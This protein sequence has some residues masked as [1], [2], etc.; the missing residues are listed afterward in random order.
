MAEEARNSG[1]KRATAAGNAKDIE[2]LK[3]QLSGIEGMLKT[4]VE[5]REDENGGQAESGSIGPADGFR[6]PS[7]PPSTRRHEE[8]PTVIRSRARSVSMT[9]SPPGVR[10]PR[11]P[12]RRGGWSD[13]REFHDTVAGL[14]ED[15]DLQR[16]VSQLLCQNLNPVAHSNAGKRFFAY[17]HVVRGRK[18]VKTGLGELTL[19]E[20]NFGLIQVMKGHDGQIRKSIGQHIEDLNEDAINYAWQ[21]VRAWSEEVCTRIH[22]NRLN[23]L[24]ETRIE[25]LRLKM[26]QVFRGRGNDQDRQDGDG[27]RMDPDIAQ[28]KPGPPCRQFNFGNC[29]SPDDHLVNGY[30]HL[31]ICSFCIYNKCVFLKHPERECKGKRF[32]NDRKKNAG[33]GNDSRSGGAQ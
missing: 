27:Y 2:G 29:Q 5:R 28:G 10:E 32:K 14:N 23:W 8:E 21:D 6:R 15:D 19:A 18:K 24:D 30:R 33:Q 17:A 26:S 16:R 3:N 13:S 31:H 12:V 20:Y 22:E 11:S 1:K 25:Y 7:A 9:R 4:L